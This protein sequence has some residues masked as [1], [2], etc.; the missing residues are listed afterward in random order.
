MRISVSF[1]LLGLLFLTSCGREPQEDIMEVRQQEEVT[2]SI[3]TL[4]GEFIFLDGAAVLKGKDFIYGVEID[5]LARKLAD[6]VKP[7]KTDNF[8]MV[9]VTVKAKIIL[10]PG[11]DG[12]DEIVQ[13][14]EIIKI[15]KK[16]S[17]DPAE[18]PSE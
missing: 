9:P 18:P 4:E 8:D 13:I 16:N 12:Y 2:D 14:R 10:N 1:I 3:P 15:P 6:Q 11:R 7:L 17:S 5:S